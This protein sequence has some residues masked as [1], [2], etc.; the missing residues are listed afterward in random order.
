MLS[1]TKIAV[2]MPEA[3][4]QLLTGYGEVI[5]PTMG[6]TL[7]QAGQ[8][9]DYLYVIINGDIHL[10]DKNPAKKLVW[11]GPGDFLGEVGFIL[12]TPRT[13]TAEVASRD[14]CLW[15]LHR[16]VMWQHQGCD[17]LRML[18]HLLIALSPYIHIRLNKLLQPNKQAPDLIEN[19]C[20][21]THPAIQ[22]VAAGLRREDA[23][24]TS[25]A[26][27][28]YIRDIPYRFGAWHLKASETLSLGYGNCTTKANLQVALLRA[29]GI[30]AGVNEISVKPQLL[31]PLM[32]EGYRHRVRPKVKHYFAVAHLDERW[33]PCEASFPQE[34]LEIVGRSMP[35]VKHH[36]KMV[37]ERGNP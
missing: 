14:C 20:D 33:V 32:P 6:E 16:A 24:D 2:A 11:L 7:F 1:Q 34:T 31:L 28:N 15:R 4:L 36:A 18:G 19:H 21:S 29:N 22:Q 5:Y 35:E 30:A 25:I 3:D 27:W 8:R 26:I 9:G 10:K 13:K 23:W 37:M 12:A 17:Q